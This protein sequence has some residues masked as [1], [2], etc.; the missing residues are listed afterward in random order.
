MSKYTSNNKGSQLT[1]YHEDPECPR[2]KNESRERKDSYI[3]YH[4]LKP[5]FACSDGEPP[6]R[7]NHDYRYQDAS[8]DEDNDPLNRIHD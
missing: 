1:R 4:D 7:G 5:C 2:M 6:E 3:Q 8:I